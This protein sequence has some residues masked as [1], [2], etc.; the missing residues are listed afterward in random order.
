MRDGR[1]G[2]QERE[3]AGSRMTVVGPE[4][5]VGGGGGQPF[6]P[7]LCN[8]LDLKVVGRLEEGRQSALGEEDLTLVHV[9]HQG[10]QDVG[11]DLKKGHKR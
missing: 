11:R 4:R 7:A 9:R 10:L 5:E 6:A 2:R 1:R 8:A 3:V